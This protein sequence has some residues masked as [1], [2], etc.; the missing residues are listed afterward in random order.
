MRARGLPL[1][2]ILLGLALLAALVWNLAHAAEVRG[3]RLGSGPTG[4]RAE[5]QVDREA[6][7]SLISL[8]NPD[9]LVI[10]LPDSRAAGSLALPPAAGVVK[11]VRA[12]QPVAGTTRIVFDLASP[13]VALKP[14][15]ESGPDGTRLVIEWPG[16]GHPDPI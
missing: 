10:D 13:V 16:D 12:G 7:F 1:Q 2:Q 11:G 3:V 9:R 8:Q 6:E 15:F 14:R 4:T 5:V